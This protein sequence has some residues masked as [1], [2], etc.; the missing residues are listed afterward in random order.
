LT[1]YSTRRN[2]QGLVDFI[3][4]PEKVYRRRLAKLASHRILDQLA[5]ESIFYIHLLFY[6]DSS[7]NFNFT[8]VEMDD[9]FSPLDFS[10]ING[11]PHAILRKTIE[12]LPSFKEIM[13]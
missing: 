4:E 10:A 1:K 12:K 8:K 3:P 9:Y 2:S 5:S 6:K 13:L 7:L 11:Y